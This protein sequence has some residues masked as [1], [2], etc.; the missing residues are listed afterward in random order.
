V[1]P[2]V[3]VFLIGIGNAFAEIVTLLQAKMNWKVRPWQ[4]YLPLVVLGLALPGISL[5]HTEALQP[6][7]PAQAHFINI[8]EQ[9]NL[10]A[11]EDAVVIARKPGLFYLFSKRKSLNYRYTE[12]TAEQLEFFEKNN[13]SY[14]LFDNL[15]YKS[16]ERYLLPVIKQNEQR[17]TFL[18]SL[19]NP[20]TILFQ[21][22]PEQK[23]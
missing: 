12:N 10:N 22:N 17:F 23:Q 11:P 2:L 16:L 4:Q 1:L 9:V 8:A 5:L 14:V 6:Y 3:P 13:V 19:E 21:F 20:E 15:G 7:P 18:V